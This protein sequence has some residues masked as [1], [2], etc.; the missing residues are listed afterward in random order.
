MIDYES[1]KEKLEKALS[2]KNPLTDK[3][4]I[5]KI[6]EKLWWENVIPALNKISIEAAN[7][8]QE[9]T[10]R[11]YPKS[12]YLVDMNGNYIPGSLT[13]DYQQYFEQTPTRLLS[14]TLVL[15]YF[16]GFLDASGDHE[17]HEGAVEARERII[18]T[19]NLGK[20]SH[21]NSKLSQS[22]PSDQSMPLGH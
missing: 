9:E 18:N 20:A 6:E 17:M 12:S 5:D 2:A 10:K 3:N 4:C 14:M 7:E 13:T 8:L 19:Y 1:H 22:K 16:L 21:P 11:L 15:S